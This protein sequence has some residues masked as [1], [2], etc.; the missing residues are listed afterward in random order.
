V[1]LDCLFPGYAGS[2]FE[3]FC[4]VGTAHHLGFRQFQSHKYLNLATYLQQ[5]EQEKSS[6]LPLFPTS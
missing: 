5:R 6:L 4:R 2:R 1:K 3:I